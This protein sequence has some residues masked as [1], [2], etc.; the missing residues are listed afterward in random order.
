M[1]N[2]C[3][4]NAKI[5]PKSCQNNVKIMSQCHNVTTSQR[6]S[7]AWYITTRVYMAHLPSYRQ[8]CVGRRNWP[9]PLRRAIHIVQVV[10]LPQCHNVTV[11][12]RCTCAC[13]WGLAVGHS[14]HVRRLRPT[15]RSIDRNNS[16]FFFGD[17]F[18]LLTVRTYVRDWWMC[19]SV[20]IVDSCTES[21]P[22]EWY[23]R[24]ILYS[25]YSVKT[26]QW[27][28]KKHHTQQSNRNTK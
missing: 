23:A 2:L 16:G 11:S 27:C 7:V 19:M 6:H 14:V 20:V 9:L 22:R 17:F 13:R 5:K 12:H 26:L 8:R 21:P 24:G 10:C 18:V 4:N 28:T 15:S 1:S 3:Q 25:Y